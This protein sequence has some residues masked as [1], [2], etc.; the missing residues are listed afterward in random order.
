MFK[1]GK[2]ILILVQYKDFENVQTDQVL[3]CAV[4]MHN[5]V[6]NEHTFSPEDIEIMWLQCLDRKSF[7]RN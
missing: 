7:R 2:D 6:D 4:G 1:N 5:D 3:G